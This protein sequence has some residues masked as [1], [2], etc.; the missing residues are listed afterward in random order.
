MSPIDELIARSY[1]PGSEYYY[2]TLFLKKD[3]QQQQ[4]LLILQNTLENLLY[5]SIDSAIRF[6]K[7]NWWIDELKNTPVAT[8]SCLKHPISK[9]I[10]FNVIDDGL[11]K[12]VIIDIASISQNGITNIDSHLKRWQWIINTLAPN[13]NENDIN[14][15]AYVLFNFK[16]LKNTAKDFSYNYQMIERSP[17]Y[18]SHKHITNTQSDVIDHFI[19]SE[20]ALIEETITRLNNTILPQLLLTQIKLIQKSLNKIKKR[21]NS[22]YNNDYILSPLRQLFICYFARNKQVL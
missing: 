7:I 22:I 21:P 16:N 9:A 17:K 19:L 4:L 12:N 13:L 2:P 20:M 5:T 6:K 18:L 8:T 10:N 14:S 1:Q 15:I 3:K 11:I